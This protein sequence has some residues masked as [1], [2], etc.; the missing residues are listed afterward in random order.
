MLRNPWLSIPGSHPYVL[1]EDA[2]YILEFN[3]RAKERERIDTHLLPEPFFGRRDA[4]VVV[5]LLNPGLG[6]N[7]RRH[8]KNR[9]F[10]DLLLSDIHSPTPANHFHLT[11]PTEGPG[12]RWWNRACKELSQ[13]L[14]PDVVARNLLS[15]EFSPYHSQAFA[16]AHL[17]LPSQQYGFELVRQAIARKAFIVCM[18]GLR[19]WTGAVPELGTYKRL[20]TPK[21]NRTAALSAGNLPQYEQVREALRGG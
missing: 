19:I 17:R 5:L 6:A 20:L 7:D 16:H 2:P 10:T 15:V 18:R 13:D 9:Q 1:E 11:D 12:H 21:S 14:G 8:H 3:R 4:P